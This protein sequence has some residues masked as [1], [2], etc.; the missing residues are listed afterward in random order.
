MFGLS[1]TNYSNN[2]KN[3]NNNNNNTSNNE[4]N[5]TKNQDQTRIHRKNKKT[6]EQQTISLAQRSFPSETRFSFTILLVFVNT[7]KKIQQIK[8]K[9]KA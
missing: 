9:T 8:R 3:N 6:N 2:S 4:N 5:R 1:D 7:V